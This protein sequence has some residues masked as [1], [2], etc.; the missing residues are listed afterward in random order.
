[1]G[2]LTGSGVRDKVSAGQVRGGLPRHLQLPQRSDLSP[3][4][5]QVGASCPPVLVYRPATEVGCLAYCIVVL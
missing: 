3:H 2:V 4:H 1:M 5:R